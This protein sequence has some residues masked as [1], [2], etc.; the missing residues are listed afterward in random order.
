MTISFNQIPAGTRVPFVFA[1]FD[2]SRAQRGPALL[3]Y[4]ALLIGQKTS[5]GSATANAIYKVTNES[6][7]ISLAGRGSLA[8]RMARA[9]FANQG[10]ATETWLGVL[11]D[12]NAAVAAS[13]SIVVAGPAT[14]AGSIALY[15]GGE[16]ITVG[17]ASG[18]SANTIASSINTAINANADLPVTSSVSSATVTI[19][20]K[21]AGV[22]GNEVDIRQNYNDGDATPAGVGLTI[23]AM[24]SGATNPVLGSLLTNMGDT[25]FNIIAMPYKD[26][27]SLGVLETEL[28]RRFAP[29]VMAD[30]LAIAA[31]V[32]SYAN[33]TTLGNSRNSP[34]LCILGVRK[35]PT[36]AFEIAAAAA[37]SIAFYG[38]Q[39]PARPFQTLRLINVLPPAESDKL[40]FSERDLMLKNGIGTLK[41]EAGGVVQLE[42][43]ITTYKT[44]AVGASDVSYLD[45]TTM[46]TLMYLRYS[47]RV[48]IAT[49][50][51]RHKLGDDGTAYGAG[52]KIMTPGIGR[53]ETI[54]WF[55][56]MQQ[57]GLVEGSTDALTQFKTDLIVERNVSDRN[58]LD[59]RMSPDLINQL[60][61][62]AA[63]F[64]FIL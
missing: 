59:I 32:D 53:A 3:D 37:A 58:R 4:R 44:N 17:V 57:L 48:R 24:A 2:S 63:L 25:W 18:A 1:E 26:A 5:G 30:G 52:Q 55:Q 13:G 21:N 23:T 40:S 16:R 35:S 38:K 6:Q 47:F 33:M 64:E 27:T 56:D 54:H 41:N 60:M 10:T 22:V 50:F 29:P 51:P 9:W 14:A 31:V 46:L 8:H 43:V 62:V 36:S 45:A 49:K 20:A 19:T 42:R 7:V 39:D 28:A 12:D 34:S 15:I 11:A 61:G